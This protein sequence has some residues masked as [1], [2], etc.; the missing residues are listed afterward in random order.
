MTFIDI[1][2]ENVVL[3]NLRNGQLPKLLRIMQNIVQYISFRQNENVIL[4]TFFQQISSLKLG[5]TGY[6]ACVFINLVKPV[7][8]LYP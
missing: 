8:G 6:A 1:Y 5:I 2:I 4:R 7:I 3:V